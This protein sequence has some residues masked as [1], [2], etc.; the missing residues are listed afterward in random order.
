[1]PLGPDPLALRVDDAE[2]VVPLREVLSFRGE[3]RVRAVQVDR[4]G[5]DLNVMVA[6]GHHTA[7]LRELAVRPGLGI[8]ARADEITMLLALDADLAA[9]DRS[10]RTWSLDALDAVRLDQGQQVTAVSTG[11][12]AVI[13]IQKVMKTAG[14]HTPFIGQTHAARDDLRREQ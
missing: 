2:V 12:V 14:P 10:G 8:A 11:A 13:R 6:R 1:M 7:T 5:Q 4:P 9:R 3:A